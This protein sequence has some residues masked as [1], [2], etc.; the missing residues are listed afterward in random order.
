MAGYDIDLAP[1]EKEI[2]ERGAG[3]VA[4]QVPEGLKTR[5]IDIAGELEKR[6]GCVVILS[7]DPCFGAC[8]LALDTGRLGA[9]VLVHVGH[10]KLPIGEDAMPV[11]FV[12]AAFGADIGG[13]VGKSIQMLEGRVGLLTTVQ[14]VHLMG[15]ARTALESAGMH[16]VVRDGDGR[17]AHQGQV[18]GCNLSAA[19]AVKD[20]VDTYL[21]IGSGDFHP[22]GVALA[23]GKKVV[24]ADPYSGEVRELGDVQ[25]RFLRKR[26]AAMTLAKEAKRWGVLLSTKTGQARPSLALDVKAALEAAGREAWLVSQGHIDPA[27]LMGLGLE[28]CVSVA[29]P[30]IAI[31]E[32]GRYGMPILTPKELRVVL[33][34]AELERYELDEI[35]G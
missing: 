19:R 17:I 7:A 25:Q 1:A 15:E 9:E 26:F 23:T 2:K 3:V 31:D 18:L 35:T 22:L 13:L 32:G 16:V 4:L 34:E 12:E 27:N 8:D 29:C 20:E 6:T 28:A 5:A 21:F 30:R 33:G 24:V 11:V 14:H 10:A